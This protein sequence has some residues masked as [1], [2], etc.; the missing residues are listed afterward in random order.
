MVTVKT[1]HTLLALWRK[2]LFLKIGISQID[3][4]RHGKAVARPVR[5]RHKLLLR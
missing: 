4:F 5:L 3:L 1:A 2:M